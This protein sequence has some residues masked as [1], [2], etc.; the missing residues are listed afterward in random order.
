M[1]TTSGR[2]PFI[3]LAGGVLVVIVVYGLW[4]L[5]FATSAVQSTMM[6]LSAPISP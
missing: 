5:V 3:K 4:R 1:S 2:M 6:P